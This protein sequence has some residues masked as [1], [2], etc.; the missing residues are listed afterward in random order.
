MQKVANA[1]AKEAIHGTFAVLGV[2]MK[3]QDHINAFRQDLVFARKSRKLQEKV[4]GRALMT[5][6]SFVTGGFLIAGW[7][8]FKTKYGS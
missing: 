7:E 3:D 2:D 5:F 4:G 6:V 8:Y 1:A